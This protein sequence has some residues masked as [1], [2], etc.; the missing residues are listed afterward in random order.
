MRMENK[1]IKDDN[2]FGLDTVVRSYYRIENQGDLELLEEVD[3]RDNN[4]ILGGGSNTIFI[5]DYYDG[6][7]IHI[8]TKGIEI[9]EED[10]DSILFE[11]M[12]GEDWGEFVDHTVNLGYSGIE[13]L[14]AIPGS[15]GAS[16]VQNI[17]A[18]GSEVKESF[19]SCKTYSPFEKKWREY[20]NKDMGFGYRQSI[21]KYQNEIEIIWS[22]R[23]RLSKTF[24]PNLSYNAVRK[25]VESSNIEIKTPKNMAELVKKIR[26]QKLPD[27]KKIGNAGSFFKNPVIGLDKLEELIEKYPDMPYY[28]AEDGAK[29]AAGWLIEKTGW[30]GKKIN[31]LGMHSNQAL[32]MVNYGGA[33]GK[34]VVEL[35]QQII[36]SIRAEFGVE[37]ETE[38]HLIK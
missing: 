25:E 36:E 30:K 22:V 33:K 21:F 9:V 14:A 29:L 31:N 7:L 12:A 19:I 10:E 3:Q 5:N 17:G 32:V 8:C 16:P 13:N 35:S 26:N 1:N 34:E 4:Y 28:K 6:N 2:S 18:Y 20:Q 24:V 37:L 27:P 38:V 11:V 23:Y 15:V